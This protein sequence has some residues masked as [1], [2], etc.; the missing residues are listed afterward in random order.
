MGLA[1]EFI[2]SLIHSFT[3]LFC[4]ECL[5]SFTEAQCTT[6]FTG[7]LAAQVLMTCRWSVLGKCPGLG[8]LSVSLGDVA[9]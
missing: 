8:V 9:C 3:D 5:F 7:G 1:Q 2:G 6:G 4:E